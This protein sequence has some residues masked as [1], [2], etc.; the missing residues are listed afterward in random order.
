[1]KKL[2]YQMSFPFRGKGLGKRFP[3]L[4]KIQSYLINSS[5]KQFVKCANG[6]KM[7]LDEEDALGL[8]MPGGYQTEGIIKFMENNIQEGDT[9]LDLG[10]NIGYYTLLFAKIVG[11]KGK[12]YAFEPDPVNFKLL[13]LNILINGYKN[14]IPVQK[15][16]SD[17]T[18]TVNFYRSNAKSH[19]LYKEGY[20]EVIKVES[21]RLDDFLP[22][23]KIDFI[24]MDIEGAEGEAIIGMKNILKR[25]KN[26]K[27]IFEYRRFTLDKTNMDSRRLLEFLEKQGFSFCDVK[28]NRN[29]TK[30]EILKNYK[31]AIDKDPDT[32]T[33][34]FIS[35]K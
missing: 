8:S 16:I 15:A 13:E 18:K 30:E 2:L 10:A 24:K 26:I 9:V 33:D 29:T 27:L 21:A 7:Y 4:R 34:L 1:M 17:K 11:E 14:I 23:E 32:T 22:K 35:R 20:H 6:H 31:T 12:V 28:L 3:A 25:N 5:R 19:N